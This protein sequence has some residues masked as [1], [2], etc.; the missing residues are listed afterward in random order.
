MFTAAATRSLWWPPWSDLPRVGSVAELLA[1]GW[2]KSQIS[3][4]LRARRWQRI[5]RAVV[6]HNGE[7]SVEELRR[8]ALINA[9][10][11][12]VLTS[13]T[14]LA[15]WGLNGWERDPIHV[16]VPR[17][18]RVRRPN[19]LR[20]RVHYTDRWRPET[21]HAARRLHRPAHSAVLAAASFERPRPACGVLAAVVQQRLA[22]PADLIGALLD[23]PRVRHRAAQLAAAH[24]IEQGAH[25]LSEIDLSKLCRSAGLPMPVRQAVRASGDGRR[26]YV[27]AEWTR[28]DGRKVVVE[29]DG[30]LHLVATRWWEDQLRQNEFVLQD[31]LVLRYPTVV[32][33]C[34]KAIV[35]S[36]L[37]RALLVA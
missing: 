34:E 9:G 11:R 24:D 30:A 4:N 16:L 31:D 29:V 37:R 28:S 19:G 15:D 12:S 25:A 1:Q 17:G 10:P 27:D 3:A 33:R 23:A 32:L 6:L 18:A 36:Q 14:G 20:M 26:R 22:R 8:A 21:M 2:T 35:V 13:F 7:P 5:G